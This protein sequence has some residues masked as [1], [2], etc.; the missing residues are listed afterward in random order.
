MFFIT[1]NC[2]LTVC[3]LVGKIINISEIV[4]I[5]IMQILLLTSFV[6]IFCIIK[7]KMKYCDNSEIS[8]YHKKRLRFSYTILHIMF[9]SYLVFIIL[10]SKTSDIIFTDIKD[11]LL[12]WYSLMLVLCSLKGEIL[13][14]ITIFKNDYFYSGNYKIH[15]DNISNIEIVKKNNGINTYYYIVEIYDDKMKIGI[16]KLFPQEIEE[17]KCKMNMINREKP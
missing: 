11:I 12:V 1:I 6:Y 4:L 2:I 3:L 14:P 5:F 16:D 8:P 15:Y 17:L 7:T 10:A 13:N 9:I